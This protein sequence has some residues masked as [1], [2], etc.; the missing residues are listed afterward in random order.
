MNRKRGLNSP[1]GGFNPL[2]LF[3]NS[4]N[5]TLVEYIYYFYSKY[6]YNIRVRKDKDIVEDNMGKEINIFLILKNVK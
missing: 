5:Y 4:M 3:I 6:I 1:Y 2:F